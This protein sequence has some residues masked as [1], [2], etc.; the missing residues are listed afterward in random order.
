M[1]AAKKHVSITPYLKQEEQTPLMHLT[2]AAEYRLAAC[3]VEHNLPMMIMDHL[4]KLLTAA[5]P[6]S[7]VFQR[8]NCGRTKMTKM[9]PVVEEE[10]IF[11]LKNILNTSKY[12]VMIDETT[13]ITT[14]KELAIVVRFV[15]INRMK[16]C[17]RLLAMVELNKCTAQGIVDKLLETLTEKE[18]PLTN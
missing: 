9:I 8:M 14:K 10:A 3:I 7:K 15:D 2:K 11:E 6:N 4:P 12:S 16:V 17:D 5:D 18:I 13:D 1:E